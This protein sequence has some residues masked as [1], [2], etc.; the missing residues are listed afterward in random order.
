MYVGGGGDRQPCIP[1]VSALQLKLR[2]IRHSLPIFDSA[3]F[4]ISMSLL[5]DHS[6]QSATQSE[7]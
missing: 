4:R 6:C 2:S 7:L 1:H 5:S 3:P